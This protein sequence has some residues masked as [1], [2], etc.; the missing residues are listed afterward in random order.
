MSDTLDAAKGKLGIDGTLPPYPAA[1]S[2]SG[3]GG[4]THARRAVSPAGANLLLHHAGARASASA[5]RA[6]RASDSFVSSRH[7]VL[8]TT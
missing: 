5:V 1:P 7:V 6:T 3:W 8:N 2:L 4:G